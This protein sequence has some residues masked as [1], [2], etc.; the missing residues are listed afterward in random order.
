MS[1]TLKSPSHKHETVELA[2]EHVVVEK[3]DYVS[4]IRVSTKTAEHDVEVDEMLRSVHAEVT[5]VPVGRYIDS[6]PEIEERDGFL[7]V[8]V[9]EEV[10]VKRLVLK[11]VLHVRMVSATKPYQETVTLRTQTP[12][13]E[14]IDGS[15]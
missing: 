1:T 4:T 9:V 7:I 6:I 11:E 15:K 12:T 13:V 3:V 10:L 8:P 2:E 14:R 5:R